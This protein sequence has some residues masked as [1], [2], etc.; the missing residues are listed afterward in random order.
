MILVDGNYFA[1]R[2]YHLVSS[3]KDVDYL[4]LFRHMF[5]D[6]IINIK[7]KYS[8]KY[9][10]IV[11][12][13]DNSSWRY[14]VFEKY[15]ISR[16]EKNKDQLIIDFY[17][18]Y[19][20]LLLLLKECTNNKV[21]TNTKTEADDIIKILSKKPGKHLAYSG[22]KDIFQCIN[23]NVDYYNFNEKTIIKMDKERIEYE[24][25]IHILLGD[26]SDDIPNIVWNSET[27]KD[28][29][30]W[31]LKKYNIVMS[32]KVLYKMIVEN[33][34]LF[35]EYIESENE[36]PFKN[37]Q[38]GI[39]T[40]EKKISSGNLA[41]YINSN[42]IIKRNFRINQSLIDLNFIPL[43]IENE[44]FKVFDDYEYKLPN[45]NKLFQYCD[46]H[47]LTKVKERINLLVN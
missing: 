19:D 8:A 21:I 23:E 45:I 31:I 32:E 41:T 29:N 35:D 22:D 7:A 13:K 15:K 44:V 38:F 33:S 30:N 2:F 14:D 34:K 27:T 42:P 4:D 24:L 46:I 20:E 16:K 39:K 10:E 17:K 11:I 43:E 1:R 36:K 25:L 18:V 12:A 26:K 40:V 5:L 37:I 9:G 6:N 28:F 47:K 3:Q